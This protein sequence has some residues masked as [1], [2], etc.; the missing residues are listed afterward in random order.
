MDC[1]ESTKID[2][3]PV[4]LEELFGVVFVV[5]VFPTFVLRLTTGPENIKQ[6]HDLTREQIEREKTGAV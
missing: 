6:Y 4:K 3:A 2:N 1:Q 5:P